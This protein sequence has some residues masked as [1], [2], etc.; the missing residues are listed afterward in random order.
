MK[1]HIEGNWL[2]ETRESREGTKYSSKLIAL[3]R[4]YFGF[5]IPHKDN[6]DNQ[7]NTLFINKAEELNTLFRIH[8]IELHKDLLLFISE[9]FLSIMEYHQLSKGEGDTDWYFR[10]TGEILDKEMSAIIKLFAL[11]KT[12]KMDREKLESLLEEKQESCL[13]KIYWFE[14]LLRIAKE[15]ILPE[16]LTK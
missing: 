11:L 15:C 5:I 13:S 9:H 12:E 8:W 10:L 7:I 4:E 6:E 14:N 3:T 16:D 2:P 1:K